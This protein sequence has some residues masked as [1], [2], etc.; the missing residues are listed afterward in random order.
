MLNS[1]HKDFCKYGDLEEG[2]WK[3]IDISMTYKYIVQ[4]RTYSYFTGN[5][6]HIFRIRL[7]SYSINTVDTS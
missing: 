1:V 3:E 7:V 5:L 2:V 4:S 6:A